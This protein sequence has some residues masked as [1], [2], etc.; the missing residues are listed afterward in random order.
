VTHADQSSRL[1]H[2]SGHPCAEELRQMY[3]W[4]RP[5]LAIPV[6]GEAVHMQRNAEIAG[7][8]G[9]PERLVGTNGDLFDLLQYRRYQAA[10]PVGRLWY[11]EDRRRL[12]KVSR[13]DC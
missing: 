9:V 8:S 6:H 4:T 7:Q 10:A 13:P 5:R 2:A 12:E 1:L 3:T 11:D